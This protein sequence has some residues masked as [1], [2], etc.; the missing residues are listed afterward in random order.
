MATS[1]WRDGRPSLSFS[2]NEIT[3]AIG[4]SITVLPLLVALAT[5]TDLSL[6]VMLLG[7]AVFQVVWG[8]YYGVPVSVEPMKALVAF[9]IAGSL[10]VSGLAAAGLLAG[11]VLLAVGATGTLA[12]VQRYVGR[13]VVRGIQLAVALVLLETGATLAWGIS[14]VRRWAS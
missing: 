14:R 1:V 10:S 8:L 2:R 3:G 5:L 11:G 4:D 12:A 13:P 7:F 9:V 6:G